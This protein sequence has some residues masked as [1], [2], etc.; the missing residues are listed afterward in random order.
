MSTT[1][2]LFDGDC[3]LCNNAVR[4]ILKR[5]KDICF[6]SMQSQAGMKLLKYYGH[7]A[8]RLNTLIF[9]QNSTL[10]LKSDAVF[11]II[12]KLDGLWPVLNVFVL[13]PKF[14]RDKVYDIVAANRIQW[15]GKKNNC[16]FSEGI[17]EE[18]IF[19]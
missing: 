7:S 15:F 6:A 16:S 10:H 8:E 19:K 9:I 13:I 17:S 11:Q 4:F 18:R 2:L 12:K 5:N 1:I 14:I 3:N